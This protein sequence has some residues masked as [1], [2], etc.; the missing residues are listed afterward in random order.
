M[1]LGV[2]VEKKQPMDPISQY[3]KRQHLFQMSSGMWF[4]PTEITLLLDILEWKR[5]GFF[6]N[7]NEI[8]WN[9]H[10]C[11]KFFTVNLSEKQS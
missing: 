9:V 7:K 2:K 4:K 3:A 6:G 1:V 11:M 5:E 10:F 8:L